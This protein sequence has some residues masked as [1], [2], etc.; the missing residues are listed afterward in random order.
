MGGL[1]PKNKGKVFIVDTVNGSDAASG[2]DWEYPL[3]SED[4]AYALCTTPQYDVILLVGHCIY[5]PH[6][7][8]IIPSPIIG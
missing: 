1:F 3:K 4:A 2:T 8:G 6:K 7:S 5:S